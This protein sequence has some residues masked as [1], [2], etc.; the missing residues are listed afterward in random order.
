[1]PVLIPGLPK[2]LEV[3][4]PAPLSP[5]D[6]LAEEKRIAWRRWRYALQEHRTRTAIE[7]A[8]NPDL[9]PFE[10]IRCAQHPAYWAA[11]YL[12]VFEPRWRVDPTA[13]YDPDSDDPD[14]E[15]EGM[16]RLA[17]PDVPRITQT[18]LRAVKERG[19]DYDPAL[20]PI[21]GYVPFIPFEQQVAAMNR[22]L[23]SLH[24][25]DENADV[26]W[27]KCR[28]WGASWIGCLIGL[29]GWTF[30]QDWP[31]APP[32]NML[33]LSRK[34]ELVDSKKQRSLFWK[35]R[36]LMRDMPDW[37]I[38]RGWSPDEHDNMGAIMN[39]ENG[40]ELAGESTT[41]KA[42]RA[43]RVTVAWIDE[44]AFIPNMLGTWSTLNET[45]DHR[46]CVSTESFE[47]GW[48]F[49][50]L[51]RGN[52]MEEHPFVLESDWWQNPLNDDVWL[53]RQRVRLSAKPE[54]FAQ[55]VMRLPYSG[56]SFVY[57]WAQDI[58]PENRVPV[59][60]DAS[61]IAIDPGYRDPTALVAI[62]E[63][64]LD[65]L[66]VLD[67]YEAEQREADF[68]APLLLPS[69]FDAADKDWKDKDYVEWS[70]PLSTPQAPL[71]F[72]Y[73]DRELRF[74]RTVAAMGIPR[75]IG[76]TYGETVV[77]ATKDSVYSRW[78]KYGI[79]VNRDRRTGDGVTPSVRQQR[80][81]AGRQEAMHESRAKWHFANTQGARIVLKAWCELR[82][83]PRGEKATQN[84]PKEPEHG[85][86]SHYTSACE[87]LAV[88]I[89][90]RKAI[91]G[92]ELAVPTKGLRGFKTGFA[93]INQKRIDEKNL[94]RTGV[95]P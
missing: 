74:A 51:R 93:T 54:M 22:L 43:D 56:S 12:R 75:F 70:S 81:F 72:Q 71:I 5:T 44:A 89:K 7:L 25:Y 58:H 47:E 24:Q 16:R 4:P 69:L 21:F 77:G 31:G 38:P 86:M 39:P 41:T 32:W 87:F 36:R 82:Y 90:Y 94:R 50:N 95:R 76:D 19:D 60:G 15:M 6:P 18:N 27:S 45:T 34:E 73:R 53:E 37:Q 59:M 88:S 10:R 20:D 91:L 35:I 57:P 68:F 85:W 3:V 80:T 13:D 2:H 42:G 28:T 11:M 62:Q 65:E 23:W 61:F 64:G 26:V 78:R 63:N 17:L 49:Y 1:M 48:D 52:E 14:A 66:T 40:N 30:S 55:E 92:R 84:E 79:H 46:W 33:F 83:K 67:S 9:I 8:G 29:W